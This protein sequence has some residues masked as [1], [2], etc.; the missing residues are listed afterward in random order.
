MQMLGTGK[1][2]SIEQARALIRDSFATVRYEPQDSAAWNA[3]AE[4]FAALS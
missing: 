1:L 2:D 4:R 3:P